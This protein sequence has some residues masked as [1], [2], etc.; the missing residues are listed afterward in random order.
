MFKCY[1]CE[2]DIQCMAVMVDEG[3]IAHGECAKK[4]KEKTDDNL[5]KN[6]DIVVQ[7]ELE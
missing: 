4:A 7:I 3:H 5:D 1:Y 2:K 6:L